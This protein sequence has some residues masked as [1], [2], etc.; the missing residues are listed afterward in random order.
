MPSKKRIPWNKGLKTGPLSEDHRR[1]MSESKKGK[2]P[3]NFKNMQKKAWESCRGKPSWNKGKILP[4]GKDCPL[5][6]G[7]NAGYSAIHYWVARY[8]TKPPCCPE[9]G[10]IGRLELANISGKYKRDLDDYKWLCVKCHRD[11]DKWFEKIM[12]KVIR[13]SDGRFYKKS[14]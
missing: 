13:G 12:K 11:M 14:Y 10:K 3:K 5:W 2:T 6:K 8:K 9:C 7:D 4:R 1:K